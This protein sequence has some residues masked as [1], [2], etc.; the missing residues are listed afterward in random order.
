MS[1]TLPHHRFPYCVL[2][3]LFLGGEG[4]HSKI[5]LHLFDPCRMVKVTI[6][7]L[8]LNAHHSTAVFNFDNNNNI[9]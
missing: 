4:T 5:G 1:H 8:R 9:Y 7:R 3:I 6:A 2:V